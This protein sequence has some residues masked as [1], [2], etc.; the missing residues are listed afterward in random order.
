[1]DLQK[2]PMTLGSREFWEIQSCRSGGKEDTGWVTR[3]GG[4]PEVLG[5]SGQ[6][7][8]DLAFLLK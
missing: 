1:M 6:F 8:L 7:C 5:V 2:R 3:L 4:T